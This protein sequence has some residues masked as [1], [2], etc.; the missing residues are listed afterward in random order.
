MALMMAGLPGRPNRLAVACV[1]L[2]LPWS[3]AA[4]AE[5]IL[6]SLPQE[7]ARVQWRKFA[8]VKSEHDADSTYV[9]FTKKSSK[10]EI[11]PAVVKVLARCRLPVRAL[12]DTF[13]SEDEDTLAEWNPYAGEVEHIDKTVQ[14]QVYRLP[15]PF[16]SREY[17]V[18]CTDARHKSGHEAHCASID[19]HERAPERSDV[20]RGRSE[21]IWRFTEEGDGLT[22]IHLETLVDPRGGLPSWVVD[23][24]GKS[25]A[26]SIVS[27]LLRVTKQRVVAQRERLATEGSGGGGE[28][29]LSGALARLRNVVGL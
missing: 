10:A 27:S 25:A 20:V 1:A 11:G 29:F 22:S 6:K 8:D 21:T 24:V 4:S 28:W 7:Y 15:W 17:L 23:K 9:A 19:G 13:L 5:T 16:A 18:R 3:D 2:T 14:R 26:V 12:L